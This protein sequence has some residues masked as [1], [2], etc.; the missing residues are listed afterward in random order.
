MWRVI[1]E[2]IY[3]FHLMLLLCSRKISKPVILKRSYHAKVYRAII[4]RLYQVDKI[5]YFLQ[6]R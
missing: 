4:V 1:R 2:I 6:Y 5:E 3:L